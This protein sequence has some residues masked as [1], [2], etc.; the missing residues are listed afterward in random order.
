MHSKNKYSGTKNIYTFKTYTVEGLSVHI[1]L[2]R[3]ER[4]HEWDFLW[5]ACADTRVGHFM[6][7]DCLHDRRVAGPSA[8]PLHGSSGL[9]VPLKWSRLVRQTV[10][11]WRGELSR[12]AALCVLFLKINH[13][14]KDI[15]KEFILNSCKSKLL[16]VDRWCNGTTPQVQIWSFSNLRKWRN[17]R[18]F[19]CGLSRYLHG[20][21]K[22]RSLL[23]HLAPPTSSLKWGEAFCSR[24]KRKGPKVE[25]LAQ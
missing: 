22:R 5:K 9:S 13:L 12:N 18:D 2:L 24:A 1:C 8:H 4:V 11:G 15:W 21:K 7:D 3:H 17:R 20:G 6:I 14:V 16:C 25:T 19:K 23:E 10:M